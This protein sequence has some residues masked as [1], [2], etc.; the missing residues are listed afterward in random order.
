M[1]GGRGRAD[2]TGRDAYQ[3]GSPTSGGNAAAN[4]PSGSVC[5]NGGNPVGDALVVGG[6]EDAVPV[7]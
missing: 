1:S 6:G 2:G 5:N 7:E 4:R 3:D